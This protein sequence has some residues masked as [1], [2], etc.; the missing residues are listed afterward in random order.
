M[1]SGDA[2]YPDPGW[3][4]PCIVNER[5]NQGLYHFR[6]EKQKMRLKIWH[7]S[8]RPHEMYIQDP[9]TLD[10][11][12]S[13]RTTIDASIADPYWWNGANSPRLTYS[14]I[15]PHKFPLM[16]MFHD[17][18]CEHAK[19]KKERKN[20]DKDFAWIGKNIYKLKSTRMRLGYYGVR[21]GSWFPALAK[22][23][24]RSK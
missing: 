23:F 11:P 4:I 14:V 15:P 12:Y 5:E 16:S 24:D 17:H 9:V 8:D 1:G 21:V 2:D 22:L 19:T 6:V 3:W 7:D 18:L 10:L 20:A 13:G